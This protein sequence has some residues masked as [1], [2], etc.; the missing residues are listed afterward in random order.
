MRWGRSGSEEGHRDPF[1]APP[2]G[3]PQRVT[4]GDG[5][6]TRSTTQY[7]PQWVCSPGPAHDTSRPLPIFLR[8]T[9]LGPSD[10]WLECPTWAQLSFSSQYFVMKSPGP[11]LLVTSP[12][13]P[14]LHPLAFLR[15]RLSTSHQRREWSKL[16]P[17]GNWR[18]A[19]RKQ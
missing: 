10:L 7:S 12:P 14:C 5:L 6:C 19:L 15:E 1:L 8:R 2:L 11:S 17:L 13:L 18:R 4:K 3:I 9:D 16:P